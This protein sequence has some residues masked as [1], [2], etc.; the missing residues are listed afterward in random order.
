MPLEVVIHA[1]LGAAIALGV[2]GVTSAY[3]SETAERRRELKELEEAMITDLSAS[4]VARAG[5][6]AAWLV[7]LANGLAPFLM[8]MLI[9][10]PLWLA[11]DLPAWVAPIPGA[12]AWAFC[13]I[14][15]LGAFLGHVGRSLWLWSGAKAVLVALG[16]MGLITLLQR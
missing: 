6:E 5:K 14:F 11:A 4:D 13:C 16:T 7:A 1:C 8:A 12:I 9:T 3:L 2:S 10:L 15:M